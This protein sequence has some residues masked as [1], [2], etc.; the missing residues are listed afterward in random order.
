VLILV[1]V[2][3]LQMKLSGIFLLLALFPFP[4]GFDVLAIGEESGV[5]E[6]LPCLNVG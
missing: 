1:I 2:D 3:R 5:P 6:P 4:C